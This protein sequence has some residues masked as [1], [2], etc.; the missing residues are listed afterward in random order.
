MGSTS[1]GASTGGHFSLNN[2]PLGANQDNYISAAQI[3]DSLDDSEMTARLAGFRQ[4]LEKRGWSEGHNV[5]FDTRFAPDSGADQA[6]VLAKEL[7]R[8]RFTTHM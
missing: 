6:Q 4:G 2:R 8:E 1:F 7:P 5:R 3:A